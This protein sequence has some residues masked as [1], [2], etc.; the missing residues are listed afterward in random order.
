[1]TDKMCGWSKDK[2]ACFSFIPKTSISSCTNFVDT[3]DVD[4]KLI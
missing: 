2:G 1:M 3:S 4:N